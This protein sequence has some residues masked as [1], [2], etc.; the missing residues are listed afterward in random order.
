MRGFVRIALIGACLLALPA[1]VHAQ[2]SITG[3]VKDSS[4]AVLPGVTVEASSPELIERVRSVITDGNGQYRIIDLRPGAYAVTFTLT[5]FSTIRREGVALTGTFTA[6]VNVELRVGDLQETVVVTGES[7]IVDVQSARQQQVIDRDALTSIPSSRMFHSIAALVPGLTI[8]GS[9]DVGGIVGPSVVTFSAYGGRGGEGR[10]QVD[11]I[12]AGGNTAGTSYYVADIGNAQEVSVTTSGGMGEAEVGGPIINIVPRTGGNIISG[13]MYATGANG[14]MQSDN[15]T[16]ALRDAGLR[17]PASLIKIW[18]LNGSMGGP[19]QRD[20]LWYFATSRYQGNRKYI[21]GMFFNANAG[22]NSFTYVPDTSRPAF[23]DSTWKNTSLRMT[24]QLTSRNKLNLFWDEQRTCIA[25]KG[26]GSATTSPEAAD[27]TTHMDYVRA[28]SVTWTS[29]AT[30]RLLLEAGWGYAG[31]LYGR[32]R[33]GNNRDMVR[34]TEQAGAIPGLTYGSMIWQRNKSFTPKW[35][36]S[37]SYVTGANNFKVGVDGLT[38]YQER[39]YLGNNQSLNY[40]LNNGVPNQLTMFVNDFK[41]NNVTNSFATYAQNQTTIGRLTVQGGFRYDHGRSHAPEQALGPDRVLP[42][43]IAFPKTVMVAGYHDIS[44]RVGMAF[45]VFG[46]G[47]TSVKFNLGRYVEA[48]QSG[49]RYTASNPLFTSIGGGTP[50]S[51][52]RSWTDQNRNFLPDCDLLNPASQDLRGSGGDFCGPLN[53]Q[54]FGQVTNPSQIW[55]PELLKGWDVRA[56]DWQVGASIQHEIFPRVSAQL[57]YVRRWYGN[58][59]ITDN[60]LVAPTDYDPYSITAPSD[61]RLPD[62]GGYVIGDLYNISSAKFGQ[63]RDFVTRAVNFGQQT[64]YYNSVDVNITARIRNG[65]TLQGGTSTGRE[66]S[67]SCDVIVDN[68]SRRNCHVALPF[69]T[70]VRA[71]ATYTIPKIVVQVSGTV[72]STPGSEIA[73]NFVV[74]SAVVAQTLGRPL[75][76][77]AANV[78]INLLNPGDMYRDRINQLDLRVGKILRFGRTRT[79]VGFDLY[80]A[81]NSSVVQ[82]SNSTFG[83]NWLTPTLVMPARFAKVSAQIDF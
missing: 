60:L 6:V 70:Q 65:L 58:F 24:W 26:G 13:S 71:L 4:G 68:P 28:P 52:T 19:I 80:N 21:E 39:I 32:E 83:P 1:A 9:Q 78:T 11:G 73:A 31:F 10:L 14:A 2:A 25:C 45:D 62:G 82:S 3:I 33:A 40:R 75:S 30:N 77:G 56:E 53:N 48:V 79:N 54:S 81:L 36:A 63:T 38:F 34:I 55:D 51:T 16:Q 8:S 46:T 7:P 59:E 69:Q 12:S 17:N 49:G 23:S 35:R 76:G 43:R 66:V 74:P 44:P 20:R 29:P 67:D 61:P 5:G 37:A 18:D 72:Q 41:F 42:N 22:T 57:G 47:R 27:G 15:Y 50:P 64:Q